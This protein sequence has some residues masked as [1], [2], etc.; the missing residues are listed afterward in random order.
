MS[1]IIVQR[2][3]SFWYWFSRVLIALLLLVAVY[4]VYG[5]FRHAQVNG[6]GGTGYWL[7]EELTALVGEPYEGEVLLCETVDGTEVAVLEDMEFQISQ[8]AYRPWNRSMPAEDSAG[9]PLS[10]ASW[11]SVYNCKVVYTRYR[12]V[13]GVKEDGSE[14][15]MVVVY[16]GY[17]DNDLNSGAR[18]VVT[19][20][21]QRVTYSDSEEIFV[22]IAAPS[23][24]AA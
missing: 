9:V 18:S 15:Q 5:V 13:D 10:R 19:D 23:D 8:K 6:G 2:K 1:E 7:T 21:V 4:D 24:T 14:T 11:I 16:K 20:S 3:H 12:T 17:E 22:T